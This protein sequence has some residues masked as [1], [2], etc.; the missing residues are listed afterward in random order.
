MEWKTQTR[1]F[2]SFLNWNDEITGDEWAKRF[3]ELAPWTHLD[4][5][6]DVFVR[7]GGSQSVSGEVLRALKFRLW[8][9]KRKCINTTMSANKWRYLVIQEQYEHKELSGKQI[10]EGLV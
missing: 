4:E 1:L 6:R 5:S 2:N 10:L 3:S 7:I 8:V 9:K